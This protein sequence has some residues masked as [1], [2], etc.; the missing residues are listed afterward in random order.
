MK[1]FVIKTLLFCICLAT[2]SIGI[3]IAQNMLLRKKTYL[4]LKPETTMIVLGHS[5]PETAF[6]DSLIHRFQ[7]CAG[8]GES[9]FY[10]YR[11]L[12]VILRDN[13]Q[14]ETVLIEYTNNSITPRMDEWIWNDANLNARYA[15]YAHLLDL[16]DHMVLLTHN[17]IALIKAIGV[18][19]SATT[20]RIRDANYDIS[21]IKGGFRANIESIF[22]K[23]KSLEGMNPIEETDQQAVHHIQYLKKC[24]AL[25]Q[26]SNR[27]VYLVRSP[28]HPELAIRTN[29]ATYQRIRM[30]ELGANI[31]FI[32]CN[33][34][35]RSQQ[36]FSDYA[37]I[38]K[39]TANEFSMWFNEMHVLQTVEKAPS[40]QPHRPSMESEGKN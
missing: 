31:P 14:I 32:D 8:G 20:A 4:R 28:Q 13:P 18:T 39:K 35:Y 36:D 34:R 40:L 17:P 9:Y 37:H 12:E 23:G 1:D 10:I 26:Q 25:C 29:E 2:L 33:D 38:S 5:H 19:L 21:K 3:L 27:K 7:N 15:D 11:K 24:I 30:E 6:N 22:E 16:N